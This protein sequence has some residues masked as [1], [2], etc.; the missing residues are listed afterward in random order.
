MRYQKLLDYTRS[1]SLQITT[2]SPELA[3]HE[4]V[5]LARHAVLPNA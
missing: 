2:S 3:S 1:R 4:E 5:L